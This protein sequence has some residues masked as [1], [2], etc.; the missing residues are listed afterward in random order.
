MSKRQAIREE[1]SHALKG[2]TQAGN[3]V[4]PKRA[5]PLWDVPL[6]VVLV[7][8]RSE[9]SEVY[10]DDDGE[11]NPASEKIAYFRT[12][13]VTIEGRVQVTDDVDDS[14]DMLAHEIEEAVKKITPVSKNIGAMLLTGSEIETDFSSERPMGVVSLTY[15]VIYSA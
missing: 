9:S 3:D 6:P 1:I 10:A 14:L 7:F 2:K 8:V 11:F 12:L 13:S 4:F 15:D 5:T